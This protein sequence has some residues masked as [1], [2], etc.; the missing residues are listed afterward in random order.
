MSS[1]TLRSRVG[2]ETT[3]ET[4]ALA[5][6]S[7]R[8]RVEAATTFLTKVEPMNLYVGANAK[9]KTRIADADT[10]VQTDPS[11]LSIIVT[12]P[13]LPDG[14]ARPDITYLYGL[15]LNVTRELVAL[16][17]G[18]TVVEYCALIDCA[19]AGTWRFRWDSPGPLAK[20]AD[21]GYF[22]VDP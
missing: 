1:A 20:G 14:T 5:T 21:R 9:I 11:A 7:F 10:G 8:S 4:A 13:A 16:A 3:F 2:V 17:D 6:T 18:T 22:D 19:H 15:D 12:P